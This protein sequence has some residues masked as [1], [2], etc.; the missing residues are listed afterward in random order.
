[1]RKLLPPFL[2]VL[3]GLL[4]SC[5]PFK[6]PRSIS[7]FS[8]QST[9]YVD[10]V[11][12]S[13]EEVSDADCYVVMAKGQTFEV[14]EPQIFIPAEPN[15][16]GTDVMISVA[17]KN[18]AGISEY[19]QLSRYTSSFQFE[20][21]YTAEM[22]SAEYNSLKV[23]V[24]DTTKLEYSDNCKY[25]FSI[26][27]QY[28]QTFKSVYD[29]ETKTVNVSCNDFVP[30][31]YEQAKIIMN[32]DWT[33]LAGDKKT[34]SIDTSSYA[35]IHT[36]GFDA[37]TGVT[38]TSIGRTVATINFTELT[39]EQL[40]G[41]NRNEVSYKILIED[42]NDATKQFSKFFNADEYEPKKFTEL[43]AGTEYSVL[44]SAYNSGYSD[45]YCE[46]TEPFDFKTKNPLS[47]PTI[48][49]ITEAKDANQDIQTNFVVA[50]PKHPDDEASSFLYDIEYYVLKNGTHSYKYGKDSAVKY[51]ADGKIKIENVNAGNTYKVILNV[52]D[53]IGEIVS[54]DV[55]K[56]TMQNVDD[57]HI[58]NGLINPNTG[59]LIN[60]NAKDMQ[61]GYT[62]TTWGTFDATAY[63]DGCVF[64]VDYY[65]FMFETDNPVS[66][67][68]LNRDTTFTATIKGNTYSLAKGTVKYVKPD[69]NGTGISYLYNNVPMDWYTKRGSELAKSI[70]SANRVAD[71]YIYN[72]AIYLFVKFNASYIDST[73]F[74]EEAYYLFSFSY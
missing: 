60:F 37:V 51:P 12:F 38:V 39:D 11:L 72:N 30:G 15:Y 48:T 62:E 8:S 47:K 40:G 31:I 16:Y 46:K 55:Q 59:K 13:W 27:S 71:S 14:E 58:Q 45:K 43:V 65:D 69:E 42:K 41:I 29:A 63:P 1:M 61:A 9:P 56:Q 17:A 24:K 25:Y 74:D 49:S 36:K 34:T 57:S 33:D 23:K 6:E 19:Q 70:S 73:Y 18:R 67:L 28:D 52:Y 3:I 53:E 22:L 20:N 32:V 4:I 5:G 21:K 64:R 2:F 68:V 10:G 44:I 50:F 26:E 54:S 66:V 35:E 7:T